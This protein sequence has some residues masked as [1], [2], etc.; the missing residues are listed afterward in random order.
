MTTAAPTAPTAPPDT[1]HVTQWGVLRS[2][3]VKFRSLRSSYLSLA[4]TVVGMV[5][6][7]ALFSG[8]VAN[9]YPSMTRAEQAGID[10]TT[11]SLRGF[12]LAQLVVGVLG[13]LVVTGE[14]GTGQIRSTLSA[15]PRRLP[16]LVAKAVVFA[17][18]TLV[19]TAISA[20]V[21]FQVGQALLSSQH[22]D[23]A[24]GAPNVLR[25]VL[26]TALYLTGVG[27]LGVGL[28]WIVRHTAGAIGTVFGVLLVLPVLAEALPQ[29]WADHVDKYLPS[30][31]GQRITSLR[32]VPTML[33]P[34]TGFAVFCG[35]LV[36]A[37][38]VG[39]VVLRRRD[40]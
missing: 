31:A 29:S 6:F 9:R 7:G 33:S 5:G 35:Y 24:L 19:V 2:E 34:W 8:V 36:V 28:G 3:W 26:G 23:T 27:L 32:E 17:L 1:P 20:L 12:F 18:V 25:A 21:A 16:V 11:I 15:V 37:L 4:A 40:S 39:A 14:Y 10:P 30:V 38:V 13:V 22:L